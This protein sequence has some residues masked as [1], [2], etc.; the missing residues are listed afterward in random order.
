MAI[1][2]EQQVVASRLPDGSNTGTGAVQEE[3]KNQ[4]LNEALASGT[5]TEILMHPNYQSF[6]DQHVVVRKEIGNFVLR[7]E[8]RAIIDE[9]TPYDF[10]SYGWN[11]NNPDPTKR[12]VAYLK[13]SGAYTQY[14]KAPTI[15]QIHDRGE[16]AL[17]NFQAAIWTRR[18][19]EF[20]S[21]SKQWNKLPN[22]VISKID[23]GSVNGYKLEM[24][25]LPGV[26]L[27]RDEIVALI[28]SAFVYDSV[29]NSL[30]VKKVV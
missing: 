21:T 20:D 26:V 3:L 18:Y 8:V 1:P 17:D 19:A 11:V 24:D 15:D 12:R 30:T 7:N 29:T 27:T 4:Q 16:I 13:S 23:A 22:P 28:N 10:G 5:V 6:N 9:Y 14:E 25:V 2:I